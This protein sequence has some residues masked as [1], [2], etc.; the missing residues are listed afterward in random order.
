MSLSKIEM[1]GRF[2]IL[3]GSRSRGYEEDAVDQR[4]VTEESDSRSKV[5]GK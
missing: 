4:V 1:D 2:E 3:A 5:G